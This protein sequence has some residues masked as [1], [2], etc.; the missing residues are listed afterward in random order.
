MT[1]LGEALRTAISRGAVADELAHY[2]LWTEWAGI[3]GDVIARHARPQRLRGTVLVVS[4]DGPDWLHE[5]RF[6]R[7]DLLARI[8]ARLGRRVVRD[9]YL[10]LAGER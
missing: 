9:L 1:S 3:V 5:L 4:V 7:A 8:N 10:V 6:L 2:P